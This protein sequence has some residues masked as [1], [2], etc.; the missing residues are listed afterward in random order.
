MVKYSFNAKWRER[1]AAYINMLKA[2]LEALFPLAEVLGGLCEQRG[3]ACQG[4]LGEGPNPPGCQ[5]GLPC[6]LQGAGR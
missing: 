5:A 6:N 3:E 4:H 1:D 2:L